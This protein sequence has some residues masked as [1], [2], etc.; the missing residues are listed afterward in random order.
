MSFTSLELR[1]VLRRWLRKLPG[2]AT[3][4]GPPRGCLG[5]N[6]REL[7]RVTFFVCVLIGFFCRTTGGQ[8]VGLCFF[9]HIFSLIALMSPPQSWV[10]KWQKIGENFQHNL[11]PLIDWLICKR[12]R[13][14]LFDWLIDW[15]GCL[16][17]LFHVIY[18]LIDWLSFFFC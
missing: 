9:A 13:S 10:A 17:R 3:D 12:V 8:L 18:W 4:A 14:V 15:I 7:W 11:P 6:Q 1:P 5:F 2:S 16:Q